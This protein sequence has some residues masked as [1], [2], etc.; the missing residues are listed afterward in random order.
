VTNEQLD[1]LAERSKELLAIAEAATD[2]YERARCAH[3]LHPHND[4]LR[5]AYELARE[6]ADAA[7]DNLYAPYERFQL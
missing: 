2:E 5:T 7:W 3:D 4:S 6:E 1:E